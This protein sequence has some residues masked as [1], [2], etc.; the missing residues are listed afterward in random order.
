MDG[1]LSAARSAEDGRAGADR[2]G[3]RLGSH[4]LY[5]G[6]GWDAE[7]VG[8]RLDCALGGCCGR[9]SAFSG[10]GATGERFADQRAS[11]RSRLSRFV[12]HLDVDVLFVDVA[13]AAAAVGVR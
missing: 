8:A 3:A 2:S 1:T 6:R 10:C 13:A 5:V 9:R 12:A 4:L 11:Q 7:V